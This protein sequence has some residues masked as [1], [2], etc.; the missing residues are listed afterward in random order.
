MASSEQAPPV[1]SP[2]LG[3]CTSQTRYADSAPDKPEV[4]TRVGKVRRTGLEHERG[5]VQFARELVERRAMQQ[6]GG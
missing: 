6:G 5:Y 2:K 3:H 1:S 4:P